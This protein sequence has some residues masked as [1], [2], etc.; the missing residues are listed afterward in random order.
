M[1][2]P[3]LLLLL[4]LSHAPATSA[5][6]ALD[7][8]RRVLCGQEGSSN[9]GVCTASGYC[10]TQANSDT[11]QAFCATA[12]PSVADPVCCTQLSVSESECVVYL[13]STSPGAVAEAVVGQC[14]EAD[15]SSPDSV[16]RMFQGYVLDNAVLYDSPGCG[17][18][19][20][21]CVSCREAAP[22]AQW[23]PWTAFDGETF[24]PVDCAAT[25]C[26]ASVI[27]SRTLTAR[28]TAYAN[29]P[30]CVRRK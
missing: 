12:L 10:D 4:V 25:A 24:Q 28:C 6:A 21:C 23:A 29:Q 18:Y 11:L 26:D 20:Q 13:P 9:F 15:P 30:S 1:V 2:P 7:R 16:C 8:Q 14:V 27:S 3:L 17:A 22:L 5:S 19:E